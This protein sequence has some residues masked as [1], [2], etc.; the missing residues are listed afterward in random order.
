MPP[1][2]LKLDAKI[3][4]QVG[5]PACT[6]DH[7]SAACV[8]GPLCACL[9]GWVWRPWGG[10]VCTLACVCTAV[11]IALPSNKTAINIKLKGHFLIKTIKT[12]IKI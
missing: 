7:L 10:S 6:M 1:E 4:E 11:R 3:V 8:Q 9:R 12:N 2:L 5:M